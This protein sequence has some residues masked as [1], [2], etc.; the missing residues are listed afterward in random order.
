MH[1]LLEPEDPEVPVKPPIS[2][3]SL[4]TA[5]SGSE[6]DTN[7]RRAS[8]S[9]YIPDMTKTPRPASWGPATRASQD[10]YANDGESSARTLDDPN[11]FSTL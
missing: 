3:Q 7:N 2:F 4:D 6:S 1:R 10:L 9:L 5:T 11:D 8:A